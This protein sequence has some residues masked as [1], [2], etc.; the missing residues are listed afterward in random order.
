MQ[1]HHTMA[2]AASASRPP[3]W[4]PVQWHRVM[5]APVKCGRCGG[6]LYLDGDGEWRCVSCNRPATP[7]RPPSLAERRA[8]ERGNNGRPYRCHDC[9]KPPQYSS[10]RCPDC[11][12][13]RRRGGTA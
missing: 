1:S 2:V 3:V 11:N 13:R 9:D 10:I 4:Q 5:V 8:A 12:A 7:P 6:A